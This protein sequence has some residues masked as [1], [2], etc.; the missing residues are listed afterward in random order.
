M[1][2]IQKDEAVFEVDYEKT[3]SYYKT[4]SVCDCCC[5]RNLYA[6]VR[7]AAPKLTAFLETFGA[8]ISRPD[9]N[10]SIEMEN[11][12]DYL[13][14][15]Y[16]VTGKIVSP[17]YYE[18]EMDGLKVAIS[19]GS[20]PYDWFPNEQTEPCFFISVSGLSLPWVLDEPFP[21]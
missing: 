20:T 3:R 21:K 9:E 11:Y 4:H 16:T 2:I 19:D 17:G 6:Q 14:I 5:C 13:F 18:T 15:G 12:I 8:D 10:S 1:I 7:K